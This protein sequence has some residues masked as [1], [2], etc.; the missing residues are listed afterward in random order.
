M[1]SDVTLDV[2]WRTAQTVWLTKWMSRKSASDTHVLTANNIYALPTR[3]GWMM[4]VTVAVLMLATINYQLSLGY[5]LIFLLMGAGVVGLFLAYR[6]LTRKRLTLSTAKPL[7]GKLG[8][9]IDVLVLVDSEDH[10]LSLKLERVG[11]QTLPLVI[12]ETRYPLGLLRL[13]S[14]WRLA[15]T[16]QVDPPSVDDS[17]NDSNRA[18]HKQWTFAADP[19]VATNMGAMKTDIRAYRAG[20][21]PRDVLWKTVA[22]RPDTPSNWGVRDWG[23]EPPESALQRVATLS[24]HHN[25]QADTQADFEAQ[26]RAQSAARLRDLTLLLGLLFIALPFFQHLVWWYPLM[27][28]SLIGWRWWQIKMGAAPAPKWLQLP[29]IAAL[30]VLVWLPFRSFSGIEASVSACMGL[31]GIKALELPQRKN[32]AT[33]FTRDHWVLIYLGLFTLSAHFLVSQSLTSSIQVVLGLAVLLY[34]LVMSHTNTSK[35]HL[36]ATPSFI[37]PAAVRTTFKLVMFGAPLMAAMFFLFP[38]FA[39]LW[40]LQEQPSSARTGLGSDMR[41]GDMSDITKDNKIVLRLTMDEPPILDSKDIYL[42]S[43]VLPRFDGRTWTGYRPAHPELP[44]PKPIFDAPQHAGRAYT[45]TP[46]D[47]KPYRSVIPPHA[48]NDLDSINTRYLQASVELPQSSNPRTSQWTQ[49]L[50]EDARFQNWTHQQWSDYV[51]GVFGTGGFRYTLAPGAYGLHVVDELLFD[52]KLG[53]CEHYASAYVVVMRSLG[54]P[55]RVVTGYQG[56]EIN[57]IDGLQVVR[58]SNAHAW[59]EY[60]NGDERLGTWQRVDPTAVIAPARIQNAESFNQAPQQLASQGR[61]MWSSGLLAPV[62][63]SYWRIRQSWEAT[64]HAWEA[65]FTGYNQVTQMSLLK[66]LGIENPSWKDL[67][68][69]LDAVLLILLLLGVAIYAWRGSDKQDPWMALLE[70]MRNKALQDGVHIPHN[71][72]PREIALAYPS[73][74]AHITQWLMDMEAARY[75]VQSKIKKNNL[76]T[77]RARLKA[78]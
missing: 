34:V 29:L 7:C 49:G 37:W 68:Q 65:W 54:I 57:P 15:S 78:L 40:S 58:N 75:G 62:F 53:F 77:L 21:T 56:A 28:C 5:V 11:T 23:D 32:G 33:D 72:T 42:R 64:N 63:K 51:L 44:K 18:S 26:A 43:Y 9:E 13:W 71:A 35:T 70:A 38:R 24:R 74:T 52:R 48:L 12:C 76:A 59:A 73:R 39:P 25:M 1:R 36:L 47:G 27:A 61:G 14:V 50:R 41:V 16:V 31:L 55:A 22:K 8:D 17:A 4:L 66:K 60:W 19:N 45:L 3:A 67:V 69:L 30:A 2:R 6:D 46:E 20:D 10:H